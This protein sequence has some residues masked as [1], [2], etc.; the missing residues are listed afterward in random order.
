MARVDDKRERVATWPPLHRVILDGRV[1]GRWIVLRLEK[2][3]VI[4]ARWILI[5]CLIA[6]TG[7]EEKKVEGNI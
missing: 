2:I 1:V 6:L 3:S 7:A 4:M 5:A